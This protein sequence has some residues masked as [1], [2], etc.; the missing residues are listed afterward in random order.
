MSAALP[1]PTELSDH[2][3][4]QRQPKSGEDNAF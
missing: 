2:I 1:T 4:E 3:A